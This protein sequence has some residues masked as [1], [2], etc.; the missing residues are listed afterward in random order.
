MALLISKLLLIS[1]AYADLAEKRVDDKTIC[2][3]DS[4]CFC[5]SIINVNLSNSSTEPRYFKAGAKTPEMLAACKELAAFKAK[6]KPTT[7][8]RIYKVAVNGDSTTRPAYDI[9]ELAAVNY[10][11][12]KAKALK[13]R[14]PVG[15]SVNRVLKVINTRYAVCDVWVGRHVAARCE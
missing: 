5:N 3:L 12:S 13:I 1:T 7:E 2:Y 14:V 4:T 11:M 8:T 9:D 6:P 15:A 10:V